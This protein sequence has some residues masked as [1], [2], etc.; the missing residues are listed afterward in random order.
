MSPKCSF[1]MPKKKTSVATI[2]S[3]AGDYDLL[4]IAVVALVIVGGLIFL[5]LHMIG[6][7]E[8]HVEKV[9]ETKI[10]YKESL[11]WRD[12]NQ[13]SE[14][15]LKSDLANA[16][17]Q[18]EADYGDM[19][20]NDDC[21]KLIGRMSH[22]RKLTLTRAVLKD[23]SLRHLTRL[24]LKKLGLHGATITN[25]AIPY[26]LEMKE[27]ADLEIG[28]T[29]VDDQGLKLLSQSKSINRLVLTLG[30]CFS[31]EGIKHICDMRQLMELEIGHAKNID[32][33]CLQYLDRTNNLVSLNLESIA[34]KDD[35]SDHLKQ[36][37]NVRHL[38]FSMCR[39]KDSDMAKI[40]TMNSLQTITLFGEDITDQGLMLLGKCGTISGIVEKRCA[41]VTA[42]GISKL[43]HLRPDCKVNYVPAKT[44]SENQVRPEIDLLEST[45]SDPDD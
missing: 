27:L 10:P 35:T 44:F 18:T 13:R 34:F 40:A 45:I 1:Q 14:E 19:N 20:L 29:E 15:R 26:L 31:N 41:N 39:L 8:E 12:E 7:S 17:N 21:M 25:K 22:L 6:Q 30:R 24:P 11:Q 36:L 16:P 43:K 32:A 42:D 4:I 23:S 2:R 28:D 3:V 33:D 5:A 9:R 38:H 37:A